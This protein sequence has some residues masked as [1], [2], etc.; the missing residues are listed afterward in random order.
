MEPVNEPD[1][2]ANITEFHRPRHLR[3]SA[4]AATGTRR[5]PRPQSAVL[6]VFALALASAIA[7]GL[8]HSSP[9]GISPFDVALKA[10]FGATLALA[11]VSAAWPWLLAASIVAVLGSLGQPT[12]IPA[13]AALGVSLG[14]SLSA[15]GKQEP[16][17][18]GVSRPRT[19]PRA[20]LSPAKAAVGA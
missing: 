3:T 13:V 6:L 2:S 11:A 19:A 5:G 1:G 7:G 20:V 16:A 15:L 9:T 10:A 12:V 14:G 4:S 18:S 8:A 17:V